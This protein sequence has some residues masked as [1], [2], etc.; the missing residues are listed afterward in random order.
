[1]NREKKKI[2][3]KKVRGKKQKNVLLRSVGRRFRSATILRYNDAGG[4]LR[5]TRTRPTTNYII[6]GKT[7]KSL[8]YYRQRR[9]GLRIEGRKGIGTRRRRS[10]VF[11]TIS[12]D[13]RWRRA[14][15]VFLC[16]Y[17]GNAFFEFAAESGFAGQRGR[18]RSVSRR[19]KFTNRR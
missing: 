8:N 17:N 11:S 5:E 15:Y 10:N 14:P 2:R 12:T 9:R 7:G 13:I 18:D 16:G 3:K 1:M 19:Q 6:D 4:L